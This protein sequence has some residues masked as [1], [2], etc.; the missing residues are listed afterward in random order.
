MQKLRFG[1]PKVSFD[2]F[3]QNCAVDLES[4]KNSGWKSRRLQLISQENN[5]LND[6]RAIWQNLVEV[7]KLFYCIYRGVFSTG[8]IA[9]V[10]L[11]KR[12]I[13]PEILHL[14]YSVIMFQRFKYF[15]NLFL[16]ASFEF[17]VSNLPKTLLT[18]LA[19]GFSLVWISK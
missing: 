16:A 2:F 17:S 14:P 3:P 15:K 19:I 9:P 6:Y 13:A 5:L 7:F 4:F 1:Y 18:L 8:A 11:R 10:I 12:L